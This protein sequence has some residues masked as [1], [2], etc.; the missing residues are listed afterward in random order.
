MKKQYLI[1]S[2]LLMAAVIAGCAG[3]VQ[4]ERDSHIGIALGGGGAKGTAHVGALNAIESMGIRPSYVSG[5]SA[6]AIIGGLYAAG[7]TP[8]E[9]DSIFVRVAIDDVTSDARLVQKLEQ[10]L[11]AK[12]VEN[13][14][15]TK[16]P[17]RCVAYDI[18]HDR[19]VVL[20]RGNMARAI[21]ASM[22][23]PLVF[24]PVDIDGARLVDG[25]LSNN[26]PV[27]VVRDMGAAKVI[28]IDLSTPEGMLLAIPLPEGLS[29]LLQGALNYL[30][31]FNESE[32]IVDDVIRWRGA[33]PDIPKLEQNIRNSDVYIH[34]NLAGYDAMSVMRDCLLKMRDIGY[35]ACMDKS[36]E[37]G[38]LK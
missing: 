7:Y 23:V 29:D 30:P 33:R 8:Q 3:G 14:Q 1:I 16:I 28:A 12:G 6:G 27:D 2:I 9:L 32:S 4:Q 21:R 38:A 19:E 13:I 35:N 15:D 22:S 5:T 24:D 31:G 20:S 36:A 10:L 25:G 18:E 17:F 37:I 34:P 11:A 26:L